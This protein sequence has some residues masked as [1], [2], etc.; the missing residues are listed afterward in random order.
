MNLLSVICRDLFL[1]EVGLVNLN[2]LELLVLILLVQEPCRHDRVASHLLSFDLLAHL[3][4]LS[5]ILEQLTRKDWLPNY[6]LLSNWALPLQVNDIV[7]LSSLYYSC[8][9]YLLVLGL[10]SPGVR[11]NIVRLHVLPVDSTTDGWVCVPVAVG[12][13]GW[14]PEVR[15]YCGVRQPSASVLHLMNLLLDIFHLLR[16]LSPFLLESSGP[17]LAFKILFRLLLPVLLLYLST[18]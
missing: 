11:I 14:L 1:V 15:S 17:L 13:E 2:S 9:E 6:L 8:L 4:V 3:N 5:L 12:V 7:V 16:C 18:L 10:I